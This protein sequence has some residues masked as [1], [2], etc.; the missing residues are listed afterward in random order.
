MVPNEFAYR[1]DQS[2][3]FLIGDRM[4]IRMSLRSRAES[5]SSSIHSRSGPRI[6]LSVIPRRAQL[7]THDEFKNVA[8]AVQRYRAPSKGLMPARPV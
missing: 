4:H 5:E 3:G 8:V 1:T 6:A 2:T 7:T